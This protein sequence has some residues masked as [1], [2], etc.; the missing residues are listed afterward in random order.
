[1]RVYF[2]Q[3]GSKGHI[4]IGKARNVEKRL[5]TMQTGNSQELFIRL[6]LNYDSDKK[7]L[8]MERYFHRRFKP[9]LVRGEWFNKRVLSDLRQCSME[10]HESKMQTAMNKHKY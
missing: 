3:A 1:M 4:K 10:R 8:Q 5:K 7:A 9:L 2:I 6:V